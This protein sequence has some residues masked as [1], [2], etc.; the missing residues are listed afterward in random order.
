MAPPR[1]RSRLRRLAARV[2]GD[3]SKDSPV[4]SVPRREAA[5]PSTAPMTGLPPL[6]PG[7]GET[8]GPN[9]K[10]DIGQEWASA[11]FH[12]GVPPFFIDIRS[13]ELHGAGHI[14]GALSAPGDSL[15]QTSADLPDKAEHITVYD[16]DGEQGSDDLAT[17]LRDQGWIEA[18]RLQGGFDAWAGGGD[19]IEVGPN[20]ESDA[21][22]G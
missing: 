19:D 16:V 17:W 1:I 3:T 15:R 22:A 18:R 9:H 20:P 8:P 4:P 13:A 6:Q 21:P 2:M 10:S 5:T 14:P 11:Q 12:S 7:R